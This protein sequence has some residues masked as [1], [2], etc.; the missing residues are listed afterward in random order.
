MEVYDIDNKLI[1]H[2]DVKNRQLQG[3]YF[4]V[5]VAEEGPYCHECKTHHPIF[6]EIR[7]DITITAPWNLALIARA[8]EAVKHLPGFIPYE[9]ALPKL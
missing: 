7:F 3:A 4:V 6:N 5:A 9:N 8:Q 1:G 2:C